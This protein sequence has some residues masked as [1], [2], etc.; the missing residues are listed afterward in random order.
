MIFSP[1]VFGV[2][3]NQDYNRPVINEKQKDLI[4]DWA[5]SSTAVMMEDRKPLGTSGFHHAEVPSRPRPH[6]LHAQM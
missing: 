3:D 1:Q 6:F 2:D 4:K 5:L